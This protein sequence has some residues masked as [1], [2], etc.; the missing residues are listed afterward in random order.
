[1]ARFD[2][3]RTGDGAFVLDCQADILSYLHTRVVAPLFPAEIEP[4]VSERLN[5]ML[6]IEDEGYVL[7]P[8][9]LAAVSARE[10]GPPITSL[11]HE[12]TRIL[13]ALDMLTSGF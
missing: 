4:K 3:H 10:L 5:P 13:A 8:Q 7:Y 9:F 6:H 12:G 2:V 11:A 1:M